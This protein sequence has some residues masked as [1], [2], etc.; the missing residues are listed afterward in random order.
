MCVGFS[1]GHPVAM[2]HGFKFSTSM[3]VNK[4]GRWVLEYADYYYQERGIRLFDTWNRVVMAQVELLKVVA[5]YKRLSSS[6]C[7]CSD[8]VAEFRQQWN[9]IVR[10]RAQI[11]PFVSREGVLF[12]LSNAY[13]NLDMLGFDYILKNQRQLPLLIF[14]TEIMNLY[15]DKVEDCFYS[16]QESRHIY[17]NGI[18]TDRVASQAERTGFDLQEGQFESSVYDSDCDPSAP[19]ELAFDWGSAIS[20]M[21]VMQPRQWDFSQGKPSDVVCQTQINEFFVKPDGQDNAMISEL[22]SR[23]CRYYQ[24]HPC[25]E[26]I[27]YKDKYGDHRNPN[28]IN[29]STF[30]EMA[31]AELE[32]Q[33]W[34]V[35]PQEHRGMEPPQSDKYLLWG[36][37][38][39]ES[40][41]NMPRFRINGDRCKYTLI[42]MNNARVKSVDGKMQKDKSSERP[43]SGVLP[44]EATH[45]S[46]AVDK[47]IWTKFGDHLRADGGDNFIRF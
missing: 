3:P 43:T 22:I 33:G 7:D 11:A 39:N 8:A 4:E 27:Y 32:R 15:Y 1:S 2:H 9:E 5:E 10:L 26:V 20:L 25:R 45:F 28:I 46:D 6:G 35:T 38:L 47:L 29:A 18:D 40:D 44:E 24:N 36:V 14:M 31:I 21:V 12:T 19:L 13:D 30:N 23:F 42:S 37:I 16:L 41:P 17:Y 34:T